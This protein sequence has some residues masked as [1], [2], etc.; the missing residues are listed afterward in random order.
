MLMNILPLARRLQMLRFWLMTFCTPH[1]LEH[2]REF[3]FEQITKFIFK[4]VLMFTDQSRKISCLWFQRSQGFHMLLFMHFILNQRKNLIVRLFTWS[5]SYYPC[6]IFTPPATNQR[7][8]QPKL[9]LR[10]A[11]CLWARIVALHLR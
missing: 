3:Y 5:Y 4:I 11:S 8:Q 6:S 10:T 9:Y 2:F 7:L 1:H